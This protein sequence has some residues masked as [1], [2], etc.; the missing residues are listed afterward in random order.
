MADSNSTIDRGDPPSFSVVEYIECYGAR[1][2]GCRFSATRIACDAKEIF[3]GRTVSMNDI[4]VGAWINTCWHWGRRVATDSLCHYQDTDSPFSGC[5]EEVGGEPRVGD[6]LAHL[7]HANAFLTW[8][9]ERVH[10]TEFARPCDRIYLSN[11]H[12][13]LVMSTSSGVC[14]LTIEAS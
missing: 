9:C 4:A 7:L 12:Y 13:W 3:A 6:I 8:Q 1:L 5:F 14:V 2:H 10:L 11:W